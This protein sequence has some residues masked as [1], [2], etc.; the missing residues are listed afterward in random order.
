MVAGPRYR[1]SGRTAETVTMELCNR[2]R[3]V[4][5]AASLTQAALANA[6][7]VSRQTIIA[8]EQGGYTPSI[9]LALLLASA[10]HTPVD[11][12]FSLH[13]ASGE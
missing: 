10:L 2:V 12:L 9:K 13:P 1:G 6:V 7:G 5:T 8:I 11:E 3:E 4:R